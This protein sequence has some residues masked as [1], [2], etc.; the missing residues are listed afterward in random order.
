MGAHSGNPFQGVKDLLLFAVLRLVNNLGFFLDIGH[1]FL[2]EGCTDNV[3]CEVFQGF[4]L[5]RLDPG[6]RENV[7]T[8]SRLLLCHMT[9]I[10]FS[11]NIWHM[12]QNR[13]RYMASFYCH[14]ALSRAGFMSISTR[15][16]VIFPFGRSILKTLCRSKIPSLAGKIS[17]RVFVVN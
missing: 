2:R 13:S 16:S 15:S 1:P 6:T 4:F 7:E 8:R 12:A 9:Y 10:N 11:Y 14:M 5:A 3:A 17:S